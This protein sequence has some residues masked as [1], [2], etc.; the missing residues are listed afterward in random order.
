[1]PRTKEEEIEDLKAGHEVLK[2]AANKVHD[3]AQLAEYFEPV[4][5]RFQLKHLGFVEIGDQHAVQGTI[6]PEMKGY[7]ELDSRDVDLAGTTLH[8]QTAIESSTR[9]ISWTDSTGGSGSDNVAVEMVARPVGPDHRQGEG[10]K[11]SALKKIMARLDTTTTNP[12]DSKYIKGHL[13][14]DNVGGPGTADNLYPITASANRKHEQLIEDW[15]KSEVKK[16]YYIYYKVNIEERSSD[17]NGKIHENYLHSIIKAEAGYWKTTTDPSGRQWDPGNLREATIIS[18]AKIGGTQE[19]RVESMGDEKET[20]LEDENLKTPSRQD[21]DTPIQTDV[22]SPDSK[23]KADLYSSVKEGQ[24]VVD[25][26]Q[27]YLDF[28]RRVEGLP[29]NI[30]TNIPR[31]KAAIETQ[32]RIAEGHNRQALT[33]V[34]EAQQPATA[35]NEALA[36]QKIS[37][38]EASIGYAV[39]AASAALNELRFVLDESIRLLTIRV[40]QRYTDLE[41]QSASVC[42]EFKPVYSQGIASADKLYKDLGTF[43]ELL[44]GK[45]GEDAFDNYFYPNAGGW[46][47]RR[48]TAKSKLSNANKKIDDTDLSKYQYSKDA[49][50]AAL[51]ALQGVEGITEFDR[52]K[53]AVSQFDNFSHEIDNRSSQLENYLANAKE[54]ENTLQ[55][56]R[57]E[58][59]FLIAY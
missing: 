37:D 33:L 20:T 53:S 21:D 43:E 30:P 2:L 27:V 42:E 4:M 44:K 1:L 59:D 34:E 11:Q 5:R 22:R 9:T 13:L 26:I 45:L 55:G 54:A 58:L 40:E 50:Q 41:Q 25:G 23:R 15:V 32:Q 14:N 16:G 19:K 51:A 38:A 39:D 8:D 46:E 36:S 29:L 31:A 6:N 48:R 28:I 56:L 10:P 52:F 7:Y 35:A 3:T 18:I 17:L 57:S 12:E 24:D 47:Q 49:T